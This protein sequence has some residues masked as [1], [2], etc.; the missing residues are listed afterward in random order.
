MSCCDN[1]GCSAKAGPAVP[2]AANA[3]PGAAEAVFRIQKM[4]CP[5]EEALIRGR[6]QGRDGI[7]SMKFNL[8]ARELT[9]RH[10]LASVDP[11]VAAG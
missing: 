2:V 7:D 10:R 1:Q 11:I 4:D 3:A 8:M 9:V 5:T 6:L